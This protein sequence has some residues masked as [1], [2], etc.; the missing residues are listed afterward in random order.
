MKLLLPI[1]KA[2]NRDEGYTG[3]EAKGWF[4]VIPF[5]PFIPVML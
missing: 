2:F 4:A 3:D 1:A 5:I